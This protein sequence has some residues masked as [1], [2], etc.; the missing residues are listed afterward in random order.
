MAT[1]DELIMALRDGLPRE[2]LDRFQQQPVRNQCCA[3][4]VALVASSVT[5]AFST[6]VSKPR[7]A[8]MKLLYLL[9][10]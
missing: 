7:F 3:G 9:P 5:L 2:M 4:W 1:V 10:N 6:D 8:R